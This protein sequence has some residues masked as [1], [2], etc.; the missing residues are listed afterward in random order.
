MIRFSFLSFALLGI[1]FSNTALAVTPQ[2]DIQCK[3][4]Q[5]QV[6]TAI[7]VETMVSQTY[8][9]CGKGTIANLE[10]IANV[11][12]NG[13][14]VDMD[15]PKLLRE[16]FPQH[17]P[18]LGVYAQVATPGCVHVGDEVAGAFD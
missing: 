9:T 14:T 18:Y 4:E 2:D 12:F 1:L 15:G 17:G 11:Q 13:G 3:V 16:H 6:N 7:F 8:R 10:V 5:D